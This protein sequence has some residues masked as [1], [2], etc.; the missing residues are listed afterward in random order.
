[1]GTIER[2]GRN[3]IWLAGAEVINKSISFLYI[4]YLA[5]TLG[6][7]EFGIY[8]VILVFVNLAITLTEWG[9][10]MVIVRDVTRDRRSAGKYVA[11]S[12]LIQL[13]A[14]ILVTACVVPLVY[15]LG[16]APNVRYL[17]FIATS[18]AL[19]FSSSKSFEAIFRAHERFDYPAIISVI[20]T[21]VRA[22]LYIA[23][24]R[25]GFGLH[26]VILASV[27]VAVLSLAL[28][29]TFSHRKLGPFHLSF[30]RGLW[31]YLLREGLAFALLGLIML[32]YFR[33]DTVILSKLRGET[34]TG[35]YN[36][37]FRIFEL[38]LLFPTLI[39]TSVF[40]MMSRLH[41]GSKDLNRM[42]Y[43]KYLEYMLLL[44]L[45]MAI[46]LTILSDRV[47]LLIFGDQ[48][49][50][51]A[52]ALSILMWTLMIAFLN[53]PP[54]AVLNSGHRQWMVVVVTLLAT[55]L[56]VALALL[57]IPLYSLEGAA[58]ATLLP[59]ILVF[60]SLQLL[61]ARYYFKADMVRYLPKAVLASGTMGLLVYLG[62]EWSL[63][64]V[65]STGVVSYLG[66]LFLLRVFDDFDKVLVRSALP[67]ALSTYQGQGNET[68]KEG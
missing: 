57:L 35:W 2:F 24:I 23:G 48:F 31:K 61:V 10:G 32:I 47:I 63:L 56:N 62:R 52:G 64:E 19:F 9:L 49:I 15:L 36:A 12:L 33:A 46:G 34:V 20:I 60:S 59:R 58:F 54:A 40:P 26:G 17:I 51:S 16:Y 55:F 14:F 67:L 27:A 41:I 1:V 5:R 68:P 13:M 42:V 43:Q 4:A 50:P 21:I 8:A 3:I 30:D 18:G 53:S 39:S 11:N 65:V 25:A 7:A 38:L 66:F 22:V 37:A 28:N 45:P 6:S 44:G 29:A